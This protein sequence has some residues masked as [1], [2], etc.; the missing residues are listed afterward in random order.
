MLAGYHPYQEGGLLRPASVP[1]SYR[2]NPDARNPSG[3]LGAWVGAAAPPPPP[4]DA[5]AKAA[6]AVL[7]L[8]GDE[9]RRPE[10]RR[11]IEGGLSL[12]KGFVPTRRSRSDLDLDTAGVTASGAH[13][14]LRVPRGE[15]GRGRPAGAK[16]AAGMKQPPFAA[17]YRPLEASRLLDSLTCHLPPTRLTYLSPAAYSTHLPEYWPEY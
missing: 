8:A 11:E 12:H 2:Y 5:E 15:V 14:R 1:A 9:A 3:S 16:Q 7:L 17:P 4:A 13:A 10:M 6:A